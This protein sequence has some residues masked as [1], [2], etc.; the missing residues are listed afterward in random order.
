MALGFIGRARQTWTRLAVEAA[1]WD[2]PTSHARNGMNGLKIMWVCRTLGIR[3]FLNP[4]PQPWKNPRCSWTICSRVHVPA[5]PSYRPTTGCPIDRPTDIPTYRP[6]QL[7]AVWMATYLSAH[8]PA[9]IVRNLINTHLI[10]NTY[11]YIYAHIHTPKEFTDRLVDLLQILP[12]KGY[13][14]RALSIFSK[15]TRVLQTARV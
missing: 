8:L 9:H 3:P 13:R 11:I 1:A 2:M 15:R 14:Y 12:T 10:L 7:A 4:E 5:L 6:S